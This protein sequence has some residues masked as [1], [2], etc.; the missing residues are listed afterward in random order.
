MAYQV[1]FDHPDG[2]RVTVLWNGT[3]AP[4]RVSVPR[5]GN[6]AQ[7]VNRAGE[8]RG[9]SAVSGHYIVELPPATLRRQSDPGVYH[10][11]GGSPQILVERGVPANAP[12]EALRVVP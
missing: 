2:R 10:Y 6:D 1:A 3:G 12:V 5:R 7:L 9:I 11:I 4:L 8:T